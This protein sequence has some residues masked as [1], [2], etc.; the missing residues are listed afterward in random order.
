MRIYIHLALIRRF[1]KKIYVI[2]CQGRI[3]VLRIDICRSCRSEDKLRSLLKGLGSIQDLTS[4]TLKFM[5]VI[6]LPICLAIICIP[7]SIR[8]SIQLS[9]LFFTL[10][11]PLFRVLLQ[12]FQLTLFFTQ[13][14]HHFLR[15][16]PSSMPIQELLNSLFIVQF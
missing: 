4:I 1:K 16:L 6:C 11:S 5:A 3:Q 2:T 12:F 14:W 9:I 7:L 15:F 13:S 8:L 10:F